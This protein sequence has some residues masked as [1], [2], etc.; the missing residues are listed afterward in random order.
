MRV[1]MGGE[2]ITYCKM[3][4]QYDGYPSG[5]GLQLAKFLSSIRLVNGF[6]SDSKN[7]ANGAGCL[8]AQIVAHFKSGVGGAYLE[9]PN[10]EDLETFNYY[11]DVNEEEQT[12]LL[13]IN[14]HSN[15]IFSGTMK[16]AITFIDDYE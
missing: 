4:Q 13:T 14:H 3:Y 12:I 9:N 16:E 8:F 6:V 5:V 7:Q 2:W 15:T 11:V 1:R 10:N